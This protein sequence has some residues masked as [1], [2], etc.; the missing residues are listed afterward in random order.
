MYKSYFKTAWRN[1]L[2]NKTFSAINIAGLSIGIAAFLLIIQYLHFEYSYD[3]YNIKKDRLYRVPMEIVEKSDR[4]SGPQLFAFTFP[5]VAPALKKD[6]PEIEEAVRFR[7]QW[8]VVRHGENKFVE[9]EQ[10]YFVDPSVFKMFSFD[11]VKGDPKSAFA[12][13]SNAVIT[14]STAKKYFGQSDPVGQSLIFENENYVVKAV[15]R[16]I[17]A[18]SHLK[19][20]I[21][22][23]YNKYIQ[24]TK[25]AG[26]DAQNSWTWSDYYTYVLLKNGADAQGLAAKFPSFAQ[27]YLG[28]QMKQKGIVVS[29]DLQPVKDIH[30]HS[31]YDYE[32]S[33]NGNLTYLKYLGVAAF[34]ILCIAMINYINLSTARTID[35]AKEVGVRKAIGA[36][37]WQLIKQF[38]TESLLINFTAVLLGWGIYL[39]SLPFFSNLVELNKGDLVMP[40]AEFWA[41]LLSIF[42]FGSFF[43]GAYPSFILSSYSPLETIKPAVTAGLTGTNRNLLGRSLVVIQ[44]FAAIILI[45]SAI[46]F[47]NQLLYMSRAD[48]GINIKQ[49]MVLQCSAA[50]DSSKALS[51]S[52]F[53][54]D[55]ENQPG[56]R[57]VALST[58][59]PGSEVGGSSNYT[60]L[61]GAEEKRCR[62]FG[63]DHEF[64][65]DYG[66][67]ILTG[68]NFDKGEKET[69][70]LLNET[71]V[72]VLGLNSDAGAIGQQIKDATTVYT[73]IGVLMDYHQKS[74][75][76][77]IDPIVFYPEKDFNMSYFSLK[78][79]TSEPDKLIGSIEQKWVAAFPESPFNYN[80]LDDVFNT[81][82]KSDRL[83]STVLWLFTL[84][85][86][87]VACLG[88]FALSQYTVAKRSK[89]ISIRK[90]L[91]ASAFQITMLLTRGYF[92]LIL[93]AALPAI[94]VSFIVLQKWL[95]EYAFHIS[96]GLWFVTTPILLIIAISMTT[97]SFHSLRAAMENAVKYLKNE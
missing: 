94:P 19:F 89:E 58:S 21:L 72:K 73:I 93:L 28:D 25:K 77:P 54:N 9:D 34:F 87:I 92:R 56:V 11:F 26:K 65:H 62:D 85:A 23:N 48:L 91:G 44:F 35:R 82:Y 32:L 43:A 68:R 96:I 66:L 24:L 1:L 3:E 88:L 39:L 80:F 71:A 67:K 64:I 78:I 29:F 31:K 18:N 53:V 22:C 57:S 61:H 81:Q 6:F 63:I 40:A 17:P 15:I 95:N 97:I 86:I 76:N 50:G 52:S 13:L 5:A 16:D 38:L 12:D 74:L 8:G 10:I 60:T 20:H 83:F 51:V 41:M 27:K 33:G 4:Q 84:L 55:L 42:L 46:G 2:K 37:K 30:L 70:V 49:T 59:I 14:L 45:A 36:G 79:N 75:Q 90:V 69:N 7:K 47:Y